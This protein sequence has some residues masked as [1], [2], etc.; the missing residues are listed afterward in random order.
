MD[1]EIKNFDVNKIESI[2]EAA[3]KEWPF[4]EHNTYTDPLSLSM[5]GTDYLYG[6]ETYVAFADRLAKAIWKA[7]GKYCDVQVLASY[8]EDPPTELYKL[9]LK[10]YTRLMCKKKKK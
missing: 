10:D 8:L 9:S 5:S 6:G 4:G 3:D 7:N 2:V 1:V